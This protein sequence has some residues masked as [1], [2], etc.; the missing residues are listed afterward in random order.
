ML[1]FIQ[2]KLNR[3]FKMDTSKINNVKFKVKDNVFDFSEVFNT[4][5]DKDLDEVLSKLNKYKTY[6]TY[7][8]P[9]YKKRQDKILFKYDYIK[10]KLYR[11]IRRNYEVSGIKVTENMIN[12]DIVLHKK[13]KEVVDKKLDIQEKYNSLQQIS[14]L[15]SS[16]ND[17]IKL[18]KE[19]I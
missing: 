11:D 18:I 6:L 9:I 7:L 4:D 12:A 17:Y 16:R 3:G 19:A 5:L 14:Y 2:A 15:I 1:I 10:A 13:F 8:I